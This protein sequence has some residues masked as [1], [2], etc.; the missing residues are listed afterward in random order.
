MSS[1]AENKIKAGNVLVKKI[2]ALLAGKSI[3][4]WWLF[5][6]LLTGALFG[7]FSLAFYLLTIQWWA[8]VAIL[9]LT[10]VIWGSVKFGEGRKKQAAESTEKEEG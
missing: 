4:V 10:G 9:L 8:G 5:Y 3:W 6:I 1:I 2:A 7:I